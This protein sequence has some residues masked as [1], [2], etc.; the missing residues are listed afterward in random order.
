M[1]EEIS[2]DRH[3]I[4][5]FEI[6]GDKISGELVYNRKTGVILL[7]LERDVWDPRK[8]VGN[9][10]YILG[11]LNSGTKVTLFQNRCV[12]DH[13]WN[14]RRQNLQFVAD[15]IVFGHET[16]EQK[17]F[18]KLTCV[19]ENGLHWSRLSTIKEEQDGIRFEPQEARIYHWYGAKIKF[20]S[21][22]ENGLGKMP[23]D[24]VSE[25]VERLQIE[26]EAEDK[27]EI[28]FFL[29][30]RDKILAMI[31]FAIKDNVNIQKQTLVCYEEAYT[32]HGHVSYPPYALITREPYREVAISQIYDYNFFLPQ[33]SEKDP[34]EKLEKLAPVFNLYLSLFKYQDMPVDMVFLNIVQAVETFHS[35]FFYGDKKKKYVASV[36]ERF[37]STQ[38]WEL[39]ENLLL[40]KTQMDKNCNY[41]ILLSRLNDLFVGEYD[42]LFCEF[43]LEDPEYAQRIADT[44]HYYT[45]YGKE[46]E[47]KAL[48]GDELLDAIYILRLLL[49]YHVCK[50]LD[51]DIRETTQQ[52]LGRYFGEKISAD[53]VG[54]GDLT[55]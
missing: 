7:N 35:R 46:K 13:V 33:I 26:I 47:E 54:K 2:R 39:L 38:H 6:N 3:F 15:Q 36:Q 30:I 53:S 24:E 32:V 25:V 50:V 20:S 42:G 28:S 1:R 18:H 4:G 51:I 31:S 23:R 8:S 43:Y 14:F 5:N 27:K 37:Q 21:L 9:Q 40:S 12:R 10:E 16:A 29:Q 11:K 45:H 52:A 19:I 22:V 55:T 34:S 49:E 17:Q 48:K 44:R 41:I